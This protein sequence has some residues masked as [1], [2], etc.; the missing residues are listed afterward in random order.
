MVLFG[1]GSVVFAIATSS[2]FLTLPVFFTDVLNL[3]P[4]ETF[5]VFIVRSLIG[6]FSYVIVE[7]WLSEWRD[8]DA[9][10]LASLTRALLVLLLIP[11]AMLP[12]LPIMASVVLSAV[13]FSWSLY[14]VD[15]STIIMAYASEGSTGIHGALR[16]GGSMVGGILSGL[17]PSLFGFNILFILASMLFAVAFMMFWRSMK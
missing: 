8:G 4:S 11:L 6:A 1:A 17:I 9:V 5:A 2:A 12:F 16:R 15:R 10:K 3:T 13:A 14:T 7:R